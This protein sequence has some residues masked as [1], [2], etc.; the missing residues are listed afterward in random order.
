MKG[1]KQW[2]LL[3]LFFAKQK[4]L[5]PAQ[6]QKTAFLL[7]KAFPQAKDLSYDFQPYN[8]GP[9]DADVYHDV[10][11]LAD[12]GLTE[13]RS[14]NGHTWNTYHIAAKGNEI[15]EAAMKNMDKKV[16]TYLADLVTWIQSVS[17]QE[18][19]G[20]IYKKYP[21]FKANSIFKE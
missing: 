3:A 19:I 13:I 15:A 11:F 18:L 12:N 20:S 14:S 1:R 16:L 6:L 10:E 8:Y 21:E 2:P 7:Q 9:F 17:F 4:G 5:T